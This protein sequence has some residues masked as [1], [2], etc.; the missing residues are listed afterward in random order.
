MPKKAGEKKSK[1]SNLRILDLQNFID[2]QIKEIEIKQKLI[3]DQ[4]EKIRNVQVLLNTECERAV[5]AEANLFFSR[6]A[7]DTLSQMVRDRDAQI[8]LLSKKASELDASVVQ[9]RSMA[10]NIR[11]EVNYSKSLY[12]N[13]HNLCLGLEEEIKEQK[14]LIEKVTRENDGMRNSLA[15]LQD[16]LSEYMTFIKTQFITPF[17]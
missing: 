5:K 15:I 4:A 11:E 12:E 8:E 10:D 3:E 1:K 7:A 6:K 9:I 17:L 2:A 13:E 14:I 16:L